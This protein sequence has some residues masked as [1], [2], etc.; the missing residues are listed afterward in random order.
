MGLYLMGRD[1]T[2]ELLME[3]NHSLFDPMLL[4]PRYKPQ[5]VPSM[6]NEAEK[7]GRFY[8]QNVYEGTHMQG[9]DPGTV[10]YLRVVE[11]PEKRTWTYGGWFGQ[12]EQAP[13]VNWHSFEN[14]RILGEV[15]VESDGSANF[16]VPSGTFVYFQLLDKDKKMVQ[17]MRSGTMLMPGEINGCIGCHEDRLSVPVHSAN[18][19]VALR[20]EPARMNGWMGR[21]PVKF[22]FMEQVQPILDKRC[23]KC[24]D[25]DPQDRNKL[26]LARDMNPF[27]NAAYVNLYVKQ[28]VSLIGGGPAEIQKPYTWGSHASKLTGIIDS[29]H[30]G[31]ELSRREKE[32]LYTWMDLNGVYYPVYESA[33]DTTLA[34]RSPLYNCELAE[35]RDLTGVSLFAQNGFQR[36]LTAQIAFDRPEVSPC[37]DAIRNDKTKYRR[38]VEIIRQGQK[39][40]KQTPRG[41]IEKDLVP[42]ERHKAQLRKYAERLKENRENAGR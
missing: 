6:R 29:N 21:K 36:K 1:G 12:G 8:V 19:P 35:L 13:A 11:S 20:K 39:R 14:K 41:D 10:K 34:G 18:Y 7:A 25:F 4:E 9:V 5:S 31:V 22:S 40:L 30:H 33:F 3:G 26:V 16:E 42:N 17:S 28:E 23:V 37:L 24:H 32:I 27:F 2:E 15:P 38:A